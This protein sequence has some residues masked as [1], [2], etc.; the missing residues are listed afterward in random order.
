LVSCVYLIGNVEEVLE[1]I[2]EI[3]VDTIT[4]LIHVVEIP[5]EVLRWVDPVLI[6][7]KHFVQ[8]VKLNCPP[9]II[10][11]VWVCWSYCDHIPISLIF[12]FSVRGR[13]DWSD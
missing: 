10:V 13:P 6:G 7:L 8:N 5:E 3:K 11:S 2:G 1:D 9:V 4:V 12:M